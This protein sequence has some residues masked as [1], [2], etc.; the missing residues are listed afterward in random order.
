MDK[1]SALSIL[2]A[3]LCSGI[4]QTGA[5]LQIP[6]SATAE[7]IASQHYNWIAVDLEHGSFSLP[8]LTDIFRAIELHSVLPFARAQSHEYYHLQHIL[9]AGASGIIVPNVQNISQL[10]TIYSSINWPQAG[11]RGVGFSRA[12]LYGLRFEHSKQ[13]NQ[14]IFLSIMIESVDALSNL[15]QMFESGLA[16]SVLIGPY[17]LSA[18]MGIVGQFD[19]PEF[20]AAISL[21]RST[22]T[23]FRIP[24]GFHVVQPKPDLLKQKIADGFL[25]NAYGTDAQFLLTCSQNPLL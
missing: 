23:D 22:A 12:N 1:L 10:T 6:S 2:R 19:H 25:F 4:P 16:D 5:W 15:P 21:I 7:I 24:C 11:S 13:L 17:D 14:K 8:L 18:S 20:L 3:N 9:E